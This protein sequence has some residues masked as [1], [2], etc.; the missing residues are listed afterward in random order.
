MPSKGAFVQGNQAVQIQACLLI[1]AALYKMVAIGWHFQ[2]KAES[3]SI[4]P[5]EF[6]QARIAS[7]ISLIRWDR[8]KLRFFSSKIDLKQ[9]RQCL[10]C[11]E[12][13]LIEPD[14]ELDVVERMNHVKQV[15]GGSGFVRLRCPTRCIS[16][17]MLAKM[18]IFPPLP[19]RGSLRIDAFRLRLPG[20]CLSR[21]SY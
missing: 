6:L 4:H 15:G 7:T 9:N 13:R 18:E 8:N 1:P 11:F 20:N 21:M 2:N 14:R 12:A 3:S 10:R 17:L 16:D 19:A 5:A